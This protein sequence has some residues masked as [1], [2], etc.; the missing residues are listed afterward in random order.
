MATEGSLLPDLIWKI[1][2]EEIDSTT[3]SLSIKFTMA[4]LGNYLVGK[5]HMFAADCQRACL[6]R[7]WTCISLFVWL[8]SVS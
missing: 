4:G 6:E 8:E 5:V 1:T 2:Q 7:H 3:A